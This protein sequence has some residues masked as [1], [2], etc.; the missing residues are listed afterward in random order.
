[1][2]KVQHPEKGEIGALYSLVESVMML[3]KERKRKG[4]EMEREE[5]GK[6]SF[7]GLWF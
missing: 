6:K 5:A 4:G 1:M 2:V 7:S 3:V